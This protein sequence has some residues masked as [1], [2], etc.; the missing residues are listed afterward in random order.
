MNPPERLV[1]FES[2]F[3]NKKHIKSAFFSWCVLPS[4]YLSGLQPSDPFKMVCFW[5]KN[6][7]ITTSQTDFRVQ[8]RVPQESKVKTITLRFWSSARSWETP[9]Q[10]IRVPSVTAGVSVPGRSSSSDKWRFCLR[11]H[12]CQSSSADYPGP[13]SHRWCVSPR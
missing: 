8:K 9:V 10:T 6:A 5:T 2:L 4:W 3:L 1:Y 12:E 11:G 7:R 13:I